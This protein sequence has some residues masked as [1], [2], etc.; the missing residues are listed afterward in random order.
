ME[1]IRHRIASLA[2]AFQPQPPRF[3][4]IWTEADLGNILSD[5]SLRHQGAQMY[6]ALCIP[7]QRAAPRAKSILT[8]I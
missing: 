5:T 1:A 3:Y 6:R 2:L 7:R 4:T 8:P